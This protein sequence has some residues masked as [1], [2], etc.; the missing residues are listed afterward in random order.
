MPDLGS[1]GVCRETV[2]TCRKASRAIGPVGADCTGS[3]RATTGWTTAQGAP[4]PPTVPAEA[5]SCLLAS[6][7]GIGDIM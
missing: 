7:A 1:V 6:S 3:E 4:R 5:T 2:A